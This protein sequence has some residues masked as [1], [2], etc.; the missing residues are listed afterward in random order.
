MPDQNVANSAAFFECLASTRNHGTSKIM[1]AAPS[2]SGG[3]AKAYAPQAIEEKARA[4][5]HSF[6][7]TQ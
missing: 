6:V 3:N 1:A 7:L 4:I 2:G 5:K